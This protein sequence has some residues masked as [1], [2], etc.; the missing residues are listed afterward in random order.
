MDIHDKGNP[1]DLALSGL[2][3]RIFVAFQG[4]EVRLVLS[5]SQAL[6]RLLLLWP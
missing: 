3:R 2:A 1:A 6:Q 4:D 5:Y